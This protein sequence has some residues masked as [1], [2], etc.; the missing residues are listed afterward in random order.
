MLTRLDEMPEKEILPGLRAKIIHGERMTLV[1]WNIDKGAPLP[2]HAHPH[3]QIVNMLSGEFELLLEGKP[4][5]LREGMVYTIPGNVRHGGRALTDCRVL[6]AFS[7]V[8]E[9]YKEERFYA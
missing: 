6:D 4:V 9:D 1:Y 3:E 8:R 2:E 5:L 7:P